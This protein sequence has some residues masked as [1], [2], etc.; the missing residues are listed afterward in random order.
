[1]DSKAPGG[2]V[3]VGRGDVSGGAGGGAGDSGGGGAVGGDGVGAGGVGGGA[4]GSGG[5][6]GGGGGAAD[7]TG[8]GGG[9]AGGG[10][11]G[12]G[13]LPGSTSFTRAYTASNLG[14]TLDRLKSDEHSEPVNNVIYPS[15]LSRSTL[16]VPG[17]TTN[18]KAALRQLHKE[19]YK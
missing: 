19:I 10:G 15:T 12:E 17:R 1:M 16:G 7:G 9:G 11:A 2:A 6:G 18:G 3:G 5:A 14:T 13:T 4:G 8:S